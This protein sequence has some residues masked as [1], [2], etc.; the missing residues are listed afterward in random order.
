MRHRLIYRTTRILCI[1]HV[2]LSRLLLNRVK[3]FC[4]CF[5]QFFF[6]HNILVERIWRDGARKMSSAKH[7]FLESKLT[8][9]ERV[10]SRLF[11][12]A[13]NI[14][15]ITPS[16][17]TKANRKQMVRNQK[18]QTTHKQCI[19]IVHNRIGL[20]KSRCRSATVMNNRKRKHV[21]NV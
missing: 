11:P 18:F 7:F 1:V 10:K 8:Y 13:A 21:C 9:D 20:W 19:K 14:Q 17:E 5:F 16:S 12:R 3:L 4:V 6:L 2:V 15:N